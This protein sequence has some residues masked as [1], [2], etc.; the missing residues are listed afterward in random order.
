MSNDT[1]TITFSRSDMFH[2]WCVLTADLAGDACDSAKQ[3]TQD[4]LDI[5][6]GVYD[7]D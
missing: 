2:L 7:D 3:R 5:I 6:D 4:L 1:I